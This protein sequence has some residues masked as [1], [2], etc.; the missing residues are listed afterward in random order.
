MI[1]I[2]RYVALVIVNENDE[3]SNDE[4]DQ[5]DYSCDVD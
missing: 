2:P 5:C 3:F 1:S 4:Y